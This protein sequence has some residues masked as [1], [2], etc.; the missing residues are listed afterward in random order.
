MAETV[1]KLLL[2]YSN[3]LEYSFNESRGRHLRC[4]FCNRKFKYQMVLNQHG[5]EKHMI[6][7]KNLTDEEQKKLFLEFLRS[8]P[9]MLYQDYHQKFFY[10]EK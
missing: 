3:S 2:E 1:E 7:L 8:D 9:T 4:C 10:G 5:I 6:N